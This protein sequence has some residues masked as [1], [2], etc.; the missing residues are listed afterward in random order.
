MRVP[1]EEIRNHND[2]G[3]EGISKNKNSERAAHFFGRFLCCHCTT[4]VCCHVMVFSVVVNSCWPHN[5]RVSVRVFP[6]KSMH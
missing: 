1:F 6:T 3:N 2:G 4:N 5:K